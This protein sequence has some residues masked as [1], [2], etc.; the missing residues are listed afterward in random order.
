LHSLHS[1]RNTTFFVVF[2][3]ESTNYPKKLEVLSCETQV[4]FDHRNRFVFCRIVVFP[5][6]LTASCEDGYLSEDTCFTGFV[7]CDFVDGVLSAVFAFA[8]GATS[9]G[10][11]DYSI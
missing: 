5:I 9:L 11:V 2:A 10:N 7:L 4:L 6:L 1:K 3:Y 8:V